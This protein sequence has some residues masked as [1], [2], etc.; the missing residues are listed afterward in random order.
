[1]SSYPSTSAIDRPHDLQQVLPETLAHIE[2]AKQEWEA[3]ADSM[4]QLVCLLDD[5]RRIL[6]ANRTVEGW[7]LAR[8]IDVKGRDAHELLH[9]GCAQPACYLAAFLLEAWPGLSEGRSA[10]T[11]AE[12]EILKRALHIQVRPIAAG[13]SGAHQPPAGSFAA[14]VVDDITARKQAEAALRRAHDELERRVEERTAQLSETNQLLRREIGERVQAEEA[15]QQ[16]N[17]ELELLNRTGRA[18][19]STLDLE[20]VL[21]T[22]LEEVRYLLDVTACSIW[23]LDPQ[24]DQLVCWQSTG[25]HS[26]QVRG[27]RLDRGEGL[28][29]WVA[30]HGE[31]LI[32]PD[33]L[34]DGRYFR[35]VGETAGLGLR[36]ILSVPLRSKQAMIGVLQV[37]D[38]QAARFDASDLKLLE[39][40]AASAVIAIENAR[41]YQDLQDQMHKLQMAQAQLVHSERISAL[42]RLSASIAHEVNN[43]LQSVQACLTLIREELE[44]GQRP[45]KLDRYLGT[46]E[47]E[48]ERVAT[49]VQRMRNFYRPTRQG[50]Q[51]T[52]LH[53]VLESVLE[54][55]A[56]QLQHSNVSVERAW[57]A[58]LPAIQANP[59]HLKQVFLNLVLNA[60]DAMPR[61]GKLRISTALDTIPAGAGRP[62]RPAVRLEFGDTGVGMSAETLSHLFEPFFTTKEGGSGLGLSV[63]R[64]VIQAHA[65]QMTVTSQVGLGT[66]FAI[67]LPLEA[68]RS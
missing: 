41:L 37:V 39:P 38:T 68:R 61:G 55:T 48:I 53:T 18:F 50:M 54:L 65:G 25:P 5:Q 62:P 3:T 9:P 11:E 7:G 60:V 27:W 36:S 42:G 59:D 35:E 23:L 45:E 40:L 52:D 58:G 67:L 6:R 15:L 64:G 22:I 29:G 47:S 20:Q 66:T 31:S 2:R 26:E 4:P 21:I 51:S 24:T 13:T 57:A 1:L 19:N 16:R 8:V 49:I 28:V 56:R 32:V 12:D 43:P 44:D 10:Q 34:A 46:V 30:D 14:I 33:A 63:S 17:R